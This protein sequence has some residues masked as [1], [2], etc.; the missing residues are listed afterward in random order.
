MAETREWGTVAA[1]EIG[2]VVAELSDLRRALQAAAAPKPFTDEL[3]RHTTNLR[4]LLGT[5]G[6][7]HVAT[8]VETPRP[9]TLPPLDR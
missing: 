6:K 8:D 4:G 9:G 2:R 7:Y 3:H 5:L 1:R